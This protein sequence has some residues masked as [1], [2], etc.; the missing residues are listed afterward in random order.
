MGQPW[1]LG[2][3][4]VTQRNSRGF[5]LI[6]L[7]LVVG[8]IGILAT[9]AVPSFMTYRAR[10]SQSEVKANLASIRTQ[11][12]SY[13]SESNEYTDDLRLIGYSPT[14]KPRYL[15]GFTSDTSGSS[16]NDT[17]EL[18][19]LKGGFSTVNMV[20]AAGVPLTSSELPESG[21]TDNGYVIG[22]VGELDEDL[23]LDQWTL[24]KV[25]GLQNVNGDVQ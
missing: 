25:G 6:E 9:I 21:I 19:A 13:S 11:L 8:I 2:M 22:G 12:E 5:T 16:V 20:T 18:H 7:M 10:S 14:G 17:A 4:V 24:S 3:Q 23:N 15:Y 1:G